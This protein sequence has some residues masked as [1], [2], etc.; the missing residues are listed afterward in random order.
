M[1]NRDNRRLAIIGAGVSG[2]SAAWHLKDS[3][4]EVVT[5]EKS[6][7]LSGRAATRTMNDV[8]VDH[9][10]S[11]F[12]IDSP[13]LEDLI[14][15]EL[16][17]DGLFQIHG[18][19]F[20][21]DQQSKII[22]GDPNLN[23]E[24]KWNYRNGISDLGKQLAA[25]SGSKIIRETR[26][27]SLEECSGSW[28]LIN[29]DGLSL[30]V[31]DAVLFTPPAPQIIDLISDSDVQE[32]SL[33]ELNEFLAESK[34]NSQF[35]IVMGFENRIERPKDCCAMLNEDRKHAVSWLGFED[36]KSGRVGSGA[37]VIVAQMSPEWTTSHYDSCNDVLFKESVLEV[38]KIINFPDAGPAWIDKQR[39]RYAHPRVALDIEEV[40]N[41]APEGWFFSGD[42]FVGRGRVSESMMTGIEAAERILSTL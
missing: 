31:F 4:W 25:C 19:V 33:N 28:D 7:G 27:A 18:D 23:K 20:L 30:G 2:L 21:F 37:S 34:F 10:A 15:K 38:S 12:K 1:Q 42:S 16:P 17:T 32:F 24:T 35:S 40:E 36:S 13:I 5:F 9:G 3:D 14:L 26:V 11:Y 22:P 41:C 39:W 8:R 6:R 29:N